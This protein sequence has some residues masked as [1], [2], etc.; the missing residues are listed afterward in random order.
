MQWKSNLKFGTLVGRLLC[1]RYAPY[2]YTHPLKLD[3]PMKTQTTAR[4]TLMRG[5][6]ELAKMPRCLT[7]AREAPSFSS[8]EQSTVLLDCFSYY[9]PCR[10]RLA[11]T[12]SEEH[13]PCSSLWAGTA[14]DC[15]KKVTEP[16]FPTPP[17]RREE[18]AAGLKRVKLYTYYRLFE[19]HNTNYSC[20][21]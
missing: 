21:L 13:K 11:P 4:E 20:Y 18:E 5:V 10:T 6:S 9:L 8:W 16:V 2:S 17:L 12:E 14:Q 19:S 1:Q 7:L 15:V 3:Q